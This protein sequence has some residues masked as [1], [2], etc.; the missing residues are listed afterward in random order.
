M[1][2]T[3]RSPR[4]EAPPATT[5]HPTAIVDPAAELGQGVTIG[6]WALIG[7][8]C[9][10][11]DGSTIAARATLERNVTLGRGVQVGIG[12]ILGGDPQDLKY[13]G[14]ETRVAVGDATIIREYVTINRGTTHSWVTSVGRNGFLMTY[15]HLAHDCQVGDGVVIANGTQ[16]AGHV[17]VADKATISGLCALHQFVRVG[18]YSFIGGCSRVSQDVPPY[19]KTV[20]NPVKLFGLNSVGLQRAGMDESAIRELKRAFRFIF[21]S[22]LTV[23]QALERASEELSLI[24]EVQH[25]LR[26]IGESPRGIGF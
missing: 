22:D 1:P 13:K 6:P 19:C 15:A 25:L 7:P 10:V 20:G 4:G 18:A 11:G 24:P 9:V 23:T 26:F 21:K 17:Q 16:L 3:V 2:T 14:E 5:I 8:G 12:S